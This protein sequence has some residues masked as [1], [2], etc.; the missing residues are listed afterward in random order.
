MIRVRGWIWDILIEDEFRRRG[1]GKSAMLLAEN[2]ASSQGA[3]TL[4]LN[5]FGFNTTARRFYESVGY[6][7]TSLKMRKTL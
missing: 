4:G 6:K 3:A 2:Y 5:V 7:T 1:F